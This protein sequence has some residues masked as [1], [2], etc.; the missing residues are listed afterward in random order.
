MTNKLK[1]RPFCGGEAFLYDPKGDYET[2]YK[3]VTCENDCILMLTL[4]FASEGDA[5][6][7]WNTRKG[8]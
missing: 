3:G 5:I 1:P 7:A 6:T 8:K 2:G 4:A